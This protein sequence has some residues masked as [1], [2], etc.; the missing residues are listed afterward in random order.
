MPLIGLVVFW[1][2]PLSIALPVYLLIF[3]ISIMVYL[4]LLKAMQRPVVTGREGLIGKSVEIMDISGDSGHVRVHGEIWDAVFEG[5]FRI[6]D[7]GKI[8]DIRGKTL[9]LERIPSP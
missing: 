1:I 3:L 6:T 8:K 7:K 5:T 9:I 4:A 2:W